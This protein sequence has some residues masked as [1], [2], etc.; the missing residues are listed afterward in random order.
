MLSFTK[1]IKFL[2]GDLTK[3]EYKKIGIL[4]AAMMLIIGNYW[5]LRVTKDALF[6]LFVGYKAYGPVVKMIS[7]CIMLVAVLFYSKL[8][9]LLKRSSLLYLM[10]AFYGAAFL[11]LG[12][13]IAKPDL[14]MVSQTS[15]LYPLFSW[16]PGKGLGWVAYLLL[17]SYGSLLIAVFYSFVA[18]VMTADLAKKGYGFMF[19]FI[20]FATVVGILITRFVVKKSGGFSLIYILGGLFVLIAPFFIKLYLSVFSKEVAALHTAHEP[21]KQQTGFFEG[22]RLILTHPYVLGIFV[23]ASFYEIVHFI[24]EYQMGVTALSVCTSNEFAVFKSYQ[25]L[26]IQSLALFFLFIGGTSIFMRKFGMKF[27]LITFPVTIGF[28]LTV[29]Y[30]VYASGISNAYFMWVLLGASVAIKGL[31]YALNKPTS[32]VMYIPTS[33]DVKFKSKGW[34]DMF[35]LRA[36]KAVGGGITWISPLFLFGVAASLGVV[37]VWIFVA[38]FVGNKFNELQKDNKIIE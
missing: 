31:N 33:K 5:M 19:V 8:V 12:F 30:I 29:S 28:V 36:T 10:C 1:I 34:I 2:W 25:G 38:S 14:V 20:Q 4:A 6:N 11:L 9:D 13:F 24:I 17:E 26:G 22:A 37:A 27:C 35:G 23:V 16:I 32:E 21:K 3:Q 7:P 15:V 18:S